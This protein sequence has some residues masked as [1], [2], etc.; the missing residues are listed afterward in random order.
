MRDKEKNKYA[1]RFLG[2][3]DGVAVEA[4]FGRLEGCARSRVESGVT[5]SVRQVLSLKFTW[6]LLVE[7]T[8]GQLGTWT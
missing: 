7:M 8:R 6:Y 2:G 3:K 5:L 4:R 1:L